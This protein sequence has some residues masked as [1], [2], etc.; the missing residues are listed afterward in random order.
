MGT[1]AGPVRTRLGRAEA[2]VGLAGT[3]RAK[4]AVPKGRY[5]KSI[6]LAT[7]MGL[8]SKVDT[9]K[10]RNLVEDQA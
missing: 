3:A 8:G 5:L 9:T 10:I 7:T 1:S 4:P 2:R 6:T